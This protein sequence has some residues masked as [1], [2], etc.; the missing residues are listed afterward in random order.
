M[1]RH[2][3]KPLRT[4]AASV[5]LFILLTLAGIGAFFALPFIIWKEYR[6]GKR[7]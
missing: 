7:F 6:D 3:V 5:G 2:P 4:A 1:R